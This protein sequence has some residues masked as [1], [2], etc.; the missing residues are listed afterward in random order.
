MASAKEVVKIR[1][2][3]NK[4]PDKSAFVVGEAGVSS[5]QKFKNKNYNDK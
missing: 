2:K 5:K 1:L 3:L 4:D